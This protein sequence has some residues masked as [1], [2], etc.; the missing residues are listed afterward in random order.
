MSVF[1]ID[2]ASRRSPDTVRN[3]EFAKIRRGYDPDQ[4][5]EY[6]NQVA[7]W[8]DQLERELR[9]AR[10]ELSTMSR[11]RAT[12]ERDPYERLGA[13]VAEIVRAAEQFAEQ[14]RREATEEVTR[15]VAEARE[16]AERQVTEAREG[17]EKALTEARGE[18]E[19][20]RREAK[21]EAQRLRVAADQ[22]ISRARG[23]A[24]TLLANLVQRRDALL[25]EL[26]SYR[27]R[28][29]G[30]VGQLEP[31]VA[32]PPSIPEPDLPSAQGGGSVPP[33]P[34]SLTEPFDGGRRE[35]GTARESEAEE[36]PTDS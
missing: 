2:V 21:S 1:D 36:D 15:Q 22:A 8:I 7:G 23:E 6:L 33:P 14:T 25:G 28:L 31:V 12:P 16:N 9:Q 27:E 32:S 35:G 20:M 5:H 13:R 26:S 19:R 30:L 18:A 11:R 17:A 10:T 29:V 34:R 4:V 3:K 24:E